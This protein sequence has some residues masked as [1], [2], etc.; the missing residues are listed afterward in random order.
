LNGVRKIRA[1]LFFLTVAVTTYGAL[2]DV[3]NSYPAPAPNPRAA[4][5][6]PDTLF[7]YC[8]SSGDNIWCLNPANGSVSGSFPSPCGV[9]TEGLSYSSENNLWV[10]SWYN[11]YVYRCNA[12]DGSIISSWYAQHGFMGL[13]IEGYGDGGANA[14]AIFTSNVYPRGIW[15]HNLSNGS[16]LSS[17]SNL[18]P[19]V[20]ICW[21]WRNKI[22]WGGYQSTIFGYRA[23]GSFV[24]SFASPEDLPYGFAYFGE[25]LYVTTYRNNYLW[26]IHCPSFPGVEPFSAGRVKALFR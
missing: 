9:F 4:A 14:H 26:Q 17:F 23:N 21:D 3:V 24:A 2:G 12:D 8:F 5:R 25:Y 7:V 1:T 6:G 11:D 22:I 10:G 15:R 20:D 16:I 19:L 18:Q 13:A